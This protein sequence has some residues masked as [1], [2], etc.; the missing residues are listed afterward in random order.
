[1]WKANKELT[2]TVTK[3]EQER[4]R[5]EKELKAATTNVNT[6]LSNMRMEIAALQT[7]V[8]YFRICQLT[9]QHDTITRDHEAQQTTIRTQVCSQFETFL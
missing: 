4:Q 1:M 5:L 3:L 6:E 9:R 2:E 7:K 8:S